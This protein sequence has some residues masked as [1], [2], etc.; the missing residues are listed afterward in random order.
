MTA[1]ARVLGAHA[2]AE[3]S[4][5]ARSSEVPW[6]RQQRRPVRAQV[7]KRPCMHR[8]HRGNRLKGQG[9]VGPAEDDDDNGRRGRGVGEGVC[10]VAAGIC[11]LSNQQTVNT[12]QHA[13]GGYPTDPCTFRKPHQSRD[14]FRCA[15]KHAEGAYA[16]AGAHTLQMEVPSL[17]YRIRL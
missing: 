10:G 13:P 15:A 17:M 3:P 7:Q 14:C 6:T 16:K 12:N 11:L 1:P 2:L 9:R 8:R 4:S 5:K